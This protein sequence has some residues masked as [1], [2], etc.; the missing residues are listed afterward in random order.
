MLPLLEPTLDDLGGRGMLAETVTI[1]LDK[2]YDSHRTQ[3]RLA[4]QGI[5]D[6]VIARRRRP[7]NAGPAPAKPRL[8][9]RWPLEHTNSWLSNFGQLRRNTDHKPAHRI[10]QLALTLALVAKLI[11]WRDRWSPASTPIR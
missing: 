1:W 11:D 8:G 9:L 4:E 10:A 7:G 2:G 6:A 3:A 5:T